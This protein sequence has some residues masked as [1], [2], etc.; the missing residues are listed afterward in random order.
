[1]NRFAVLG[2]VGLLA[3]GL[4]AAPAA[5]APLVADT[6]E[7]VDVNTCKDVPG[8]EGATKKD[9]TGE[10]YSV[11]VDA[12][13]GE[14]I[15][16]YCVKAGSTKN[17]G[18]PLVVTLDEPASSVEIEYFDQ[19]EKQKAISHYAVLTVNCPSD[20]PSDEPSDGPSDEPSDGPSDEPSDGPSDEPSTEPSDE[21][22]EPTV[23]PTSSTPADGE[24]AGVLAA[25]GAGAA[26]GYALLALALAGGGVTLLVLRKRRMS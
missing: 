7:Y 14:L 17:G 15:S 1:M 19:E 3:V 8:F 5:A 26:V 23:A 6:T 16:A 24:T 13:D 9:V 10:Q 12:P 22:S 18:G 2:A 25:T 21:P 11:T 20:E 4:G